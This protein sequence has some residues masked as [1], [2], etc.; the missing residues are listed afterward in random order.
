MEPPFRR[1][2]AHT[3]ALEYVEALLG[4]A[5]RKNAWGLSESSLFELALP[6]E[7]LVYSGPLAR[8]SG[9][10]TPEELECALLRHQS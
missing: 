3:A 7:A 8:R 1:R 10:N 4:R 2:E 5:Q 9:V 6:R